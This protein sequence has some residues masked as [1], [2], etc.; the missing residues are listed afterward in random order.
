LSHDRHALLNVALVS[1][2]GSGSM[3]EGD[4]S[5]REQLSRAEQISLMFDGAEIGDL[6]RAAQGAVETDADIIVCAGGDGTARFVADL[7]IA[8]DCKAA[9]LVLPC[10]TANLLSKRLYGERTV[11]ALLDDIV[12]LE[13]AYIPAGFVNDQ[14]F[15]L[16]AAAGFPATMGRAREAFRDAPASPRRMARTFGAAAVALRRLLQPKLTLTADGVA[17]GDGK[18]S[19]VIAWI[20]PGDTAPNAQDRII[21]L[22]SLFIGPESWGDVFSLAGSA[23]AGALSNAERASIFEA[24]QIQLQARRPIQVMLDGEPQFFDPE[25]SIQ[26]KPEALKVLTA[27]R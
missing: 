3:E 11:D 13:T 6:S 19:G 25:V 18:A 22:N 14:L 27:A 20:D 5:I 2:P 4:R 17:G 21:R 9:L 1:N 24:S 23:M 16:A 26:I 7:M 15:L 10:G 12:R 8:K